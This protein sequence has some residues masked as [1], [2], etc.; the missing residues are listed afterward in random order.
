[1]RALLLI[2]G[3]LWTAPGQAGL[4]IIASPQI[5]DITVSAEQLAD[6]YLLK[7]V[8]WADKTYVVPVNREASSPIR[9]KFSAAIFKF[10]P[11]ELAEYWNRLRFQGNLPPLIQTSDQAVLGFV[12]S[13][14]GA[15]GYIDD[16]QVP[17]GVKILMRLP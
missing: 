8:F 14:P 4:L 12:R 17:A 9:E 1:M 6:I 15:I 7:K 10:P 5:P 11:Q 16:S 13:V 2:F 3:I